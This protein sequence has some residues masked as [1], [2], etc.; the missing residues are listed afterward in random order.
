MANRLKAVRF[1]GDNAKLHKQPHFSYLEGLPVELLQAIAACLPLS[2]AASFALCNKYICYV[3]GHQYWHHLRSQ[4]LEYERFLGL[5]EKDM[6]NHWLCFPCLRFHLK[7]KFHPSY[8]YNHAKPG[9]RCPQSSDHLA[10]SKHAPYSWPLFWISNLMV[11]MAMNRHLFGSKHGKPLDIFFNQHPRDYFQGGWGEIS[12]K[13]CIVANELYVRC[14]YCIAIPSS[15]DFGYIRPYDICPHIGSKDPKNPTGPII[16]CLLNHRNTASC[17]QCRD[18]I[19]CRFCVTEFQIQI[20]RFGA[21]GH[22]LEIT[23]WKNLGAGRR[24]DDPIWV[25]HLGIPGTC[26]LHAVKFSPGSIRSKFDS[27]NHKN[28]ENSIHNFDMKKLLSRAK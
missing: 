23:Y 21:T 7:P 6:P 9:W 18:L 25:Q 17:E 11:R 2:A 3:V 26:D 14:Q 1:S 15:K 16:K 4:P 22:V 5:L 13:A 10:S 20:S 28:V 8:Q 27:G 19:Q 24:S 12:S